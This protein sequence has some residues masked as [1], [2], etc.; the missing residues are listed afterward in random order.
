MGRLLNPGL[1]ELAD[2]L[3]I[4][5]LKLGH[6]PPGVAVE[7]FREEHAQVQMRIDNLLKYVRERLRIVA[8]IRNLKAQNAVLWE[9]EDEMAI[10]ARPED[11]YTDNIA[12]AVAAVGVRIWKANQARNRI[13]AEINALA[14]TPRGAEKF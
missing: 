5:E 7:H 13:I 4:L 3:T 12:F 14:G 9:L 2:R 11:G 1:G 8:A 10:Y 6:A